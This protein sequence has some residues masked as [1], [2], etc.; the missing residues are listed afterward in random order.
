M[1]K[2]RRFYVPGG[3][4]FFTAT[5]H[6]RKSDWLIKHIR[7]LGDAMRRVRD[8][9]PYKTIA[10]VVLPD[11]LHVIWELPENDANFSL[12][13]RCIKSLF[14]KKLTASGVNIAKNAFGENILWQRRFWE[15]MIRDEKDYARHVDY[16]HFNPVKHQLVTR[17]ADWPFSTFHRYVNKG[18]LPRNWAYRNDDLDVE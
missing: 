9:H 3:T 1:V 12:R 17:V 5:L 10:M 7:Q 6:D 4:Y 2:Y 15:H 18:L 13:W 16:I 14:T 11:H 8:I